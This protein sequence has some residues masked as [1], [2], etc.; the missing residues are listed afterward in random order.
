MAVVIFTLLKIATL[1]IDKQYLTLKY[2]D[3]IGA[4]IWAGCFYLIAGGFGSAA[5][6]SPKRNRTM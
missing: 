2:F 4:G 1:V 6:S 3:M 5:A